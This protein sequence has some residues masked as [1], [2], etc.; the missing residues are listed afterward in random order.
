M[1]FFYRILA[2]FR[3]EFNLRFVPLMRVIVHKSEY[4]Q[5]VLKTNIL[6][7]KIL[8]AK[9]LSHRKTICNLGQLID[10]SMFFHTN[11]VGCFICHNTSNPTDISFFCAMYLCIQPII[12]LAR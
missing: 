3:E 9:E 11:H 7:N 10:S 4:F 6:D 5:K 1:H 12:S 8:V 2:R